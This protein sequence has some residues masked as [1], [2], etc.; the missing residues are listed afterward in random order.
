[1]TARKQLLHSTFQPQQLQ[2]PQDGNSL[3]FNFQ[4]ATIKTIDHHKSIWLLGVDRN[5]LSV[6]IRVNDFEPTFMMQSVDHWDKEDDTVAAEDLLDFIE[7]VNEK[8]SIHGPSEKIKYAEFVYMSPL[9]GFTNRRQDRLVKITCNNV[10][11]A[12]AVTKYLK[13]NKYTLFHDDFQPINQFLHQTNFV[14]QEWLSVTPFRPN[15]SKGTHTNIEGYCFMENL[16]KCPTVTDNPNVLKAFLRFKAVSR[17]GVLLNLPSFRPNANEPY[18]R[19]VAMGI[20]YVWSNDPLGMPCREVIHTIIPD[21]PS[22]LVSSPSSTQTQIYATEKAMLEGFREDIIQHDPDDI[23]FF[24]DELHNLN[25]FCTRALALN[26][27]L[28]LKLDRFKN[29]KIRNYKQ[30]NVIT[31]SVLETRN[32]FNMESALQKKVFIPI[33][34]YDIYTCSCHKKLRKDPRQWQTLLKD[35]DLTNKSIQGG[36]QGRQQIFQQLSQDLTLLVELEKD[37][38]MRLEYANV[39][40]ASDTGLTDVVSRGE[41]I[42][43]YNRLTHFC[44]DNKTYV[45]R[46][47]LAQKPLR[48]RISEKPPTFADPPD[49]PLNLNLRTECASYLQQKRAYHPSTKKA[50][51]TKKPKN[52]NPIDIITLLNQKVEQVK[53]DQKKE[54]KKEE[55]EQIDEFEEEEDAEK[56]ETKKHAQDEEEAEGGNVMKPACKFWDNELIFVDD[57]ASLYPSIMRAFNITYENLV[58]DEQYLNVPGVEYFYIPINKYETVASAN[59]PGIFPK[60]LK[61]FVDNRSMIKKKMAQE[62]DPFKKNMLDFEQNSMKVLCNGTYGFCGAEKRGAL[63]A[64]KTIMYMVTALGRYLQKFCCNY[65]AEKYNMPCI[66]G[67][68]DSIFK[69]MPLYQTQN[70]QENIQEFCQGMGQMYGM[71]D[72]FGPGTEF[73]WDRVVAVFKAK[74]IPKGYTAPVDPSLFAYQHQ[75]HCVCCLVCEKICAELTQVIAKPPVELNFEN[76]A[77]KVWMGWVKKHYCFLIWRQ[78][79]PSKTSGIKITGMPSKVRAWTPW[80]RNLLMGVTERILYDKTHEIVPFL[81]EALDNFLAGKVPVR[82]LMI[83]R[84]Y[85][86]KEAYKHFRQLHLQVL[87]KIESRTRAAVKDKS[88]IYFVVLKGQDK[89][90]LRSETPEYAIQ[91]KLELDLKYYLQNQF[92][93]PMRKLLTYHPHLLN[94]DAFYQSYLK[95]LEMKAMNMM[96]ISDVISGPKK[97]LGKRMLTTEEYLEQKRKQHKANPQTKKQQ[98]QPPTAQM[99]FFTKL[100]QT[101]QQ[102]TTC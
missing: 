58:Y 62:K 49:L 55:T 72:Y 82:Q 66:Y 36:P 41:Q 96:D 54:E 39:S 93:K 48:F 7:E 26:S 69:K 2:Y 74:P 46:E 51:K 12:L 22:S 40:K 35:I 87:L 42:R 99:D 81:T 52:T 56:E 84:A 31:N 92:E 78:D 57:F 24:P 94:F 21:I 25:Y 27:T 47:K 73:T 83:S 9:I 91:N 43:V 60:M 95:R 18:D 77:T 97:L 100:L 70:G 64:V 98:Q 33:E 59:I 23:F 45:N 101:Q 90:Y 30:A 71:Q 88:R 53:R 67:D 50:K 6:S 80:T 34:S 75:I 65:V 102:K 28:A 79:D 89:L 76:M 17:D 44:L 16:K 4:L 85:K 38:G 61:Q 20:S 10:N 3:I 5:G 37:T 19:L 13:E 86:G 8:T 32:I 11:D 15:S 68:T 14:Y 29:G 1:M 63:L